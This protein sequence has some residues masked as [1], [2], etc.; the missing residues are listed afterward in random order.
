MTKNAE[1]RKH[2][3]RANRIVKERETEWNVRN[4]M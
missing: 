4:E 2:Y 1:N 3:K